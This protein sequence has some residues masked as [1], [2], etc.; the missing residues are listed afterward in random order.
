MDI[1]KNNSEGYDVSDYKEELVKLYRESAIKVDTESTIL[2]DEMIDAGGK[3]VV[4][5]VKEIVSEMKAEDAKAAE[6]EQK[7][8][9]KQAKKEAEEAAKAAEEEAKKQAELIANISDIP[10]IEPTWENVDTVTAMINQLQGVTLTQEFVDAYLER[11]EFVE[12]FALDKNG[13]TVYDDDM[14]SLLRFAQNEDGTY[15]ALI[16]MR[17]VSDTDDV[18]SRF[19][20]LADG[21]KA[22]FVEEG[23]TFTQLDGFGSTYYTY[24]SEGKDLY[25]VHSWSIW[26]Q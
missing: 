13:Y 23:C 17:K 12:E 22:V 26:I 9:D 8:A 10:Y 5:R 25:S 6:K 2:T 16:R 7:E 19:T 21:V 24:D 3:A 14:S 15:D 20:A 1:A 18:D 4:E 11:Y